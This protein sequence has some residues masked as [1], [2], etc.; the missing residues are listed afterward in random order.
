MPLR[1]LQHLRGVLNPPDAPVPDDAGLRRAAVALVLHPSADGPQLLMIRRAEREGDPW[2]GHMAFPG[3]REE[4]GDGHPRRTA[5]RETQEELGLGLDDDAALGTLEPVVTPS[6]G[7]SPQ[8]IVRPWVFGLQAPAPLTPNVEVASAQWF[9]LERFLRGEGR[10]TFPYD[11]RG[12]RIELP[13]VRLDDAFIW[14]MS[15]RIIDDLTERLSGVRP[16]ED[17]LW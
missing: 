3:G 15:L 14:G 4:S 9:A 5:I 17:R 12:H 8:L 16:P 2:S 1:P 10:D 6:F 7:R 11:Y 13:C